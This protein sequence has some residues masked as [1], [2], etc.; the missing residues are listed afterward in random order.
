MRLLKLKKFFGNTV[1]SEQ[2][3]FRPKSIFI[4]QIIDPSITI[5]EPLVLRDIEALEKRHHKIYHNLPRDNLKELKDLA[6]D[7]IIIIKPADK[8]G[9]IV[10]MNYCNYRNETLKQ[11]SDCIAYESVLRDPTLHPLNLIKVTIQEPVNLGYIIT[12]TAAF[13]MNKHPHK[14]IFYMLPKILKAALFHSGR[15]I[16]N[17]CGSVLEPVSKYVDCHLQPF[18]PLAKSYIKDIKD[19]ILRKFSYSFRFCLDV[20]GYRVPSDGQL[21][22]I[23]LLML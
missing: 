10:I 15:P 8:G 13:L 1:Q 22:T 9:G 14:P 5:F 4:P 6:A 23:N 7:L 19:L 16:I 12:N 2:S 11:L 3:L 20:Y 17:A 21:K 18:V